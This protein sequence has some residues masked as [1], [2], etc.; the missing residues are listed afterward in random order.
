MTY[1]DCRAGIVRDPADFRH[2]NAACKLI[3]E[4][5]NK[6]RD[7]TLAEVMGS[8]VSGLSQLWAAIEDDELVLAAVTQL[9]PVRDGKQAFCWHMGGDF[10]RGGEAMVAVFLEWAR[11]EGC[12]SAEITGRPGWQRKLKDWKP[13]ATTLRKEL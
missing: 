3:A 8:V 7:E 2:W 12:V 5:V 1:S 6:A 4:S 10:G 9:V 11:A 13:V